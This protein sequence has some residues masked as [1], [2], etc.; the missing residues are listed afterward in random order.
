ML[1]LGDALYRTSLRVR[2]DAVRGGFLLLRRVVL[3]R[4]AGDGVRAPESSLVSRLIAKCAKC[5]PQ[6]LRLSFFGLEGSLALHVSNRRRKEDHKL[7]Q[8]AIS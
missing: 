4:A 8:D 6:M 7:A 3:P 1:P 2:N 5:F